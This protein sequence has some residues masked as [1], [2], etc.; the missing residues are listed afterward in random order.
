MKSQK[1]QTVKTQWHIKAKK[2]AEKPVKE[3]VDRSKAVAESW[4]NPDVKAARCSRV[5]TKVTFVVNGVETKQEYDSVGKAFDALGLPLTTFAGFRTKM[6]KEGRS[7]ITKDSVTYLFVAVE[8]PA[9]SAEDRAVAVAAKNAEKQAA[10]DKKA[11][12]KKAAKGKKVEE[13]QLTELENSED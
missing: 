12:E 8:K 10:K 9:E 4:A 6:R 13:E 3:P 7:I 11:A 2:L 5:G 1:K